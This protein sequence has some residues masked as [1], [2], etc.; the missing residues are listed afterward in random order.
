MC[1]DVRIEG[2]REQKL[3]LSCLCPR[4]FNEM[5][6]GRSVPTS[7]PASYSPSPTRRS[8]SPSPAFLT[9]GFIP[10]SPLRGR[11]Q[12]FGSNSQQQQPVA[13]QAGHGTKQHVS[14]WGW[15]SVY[16]EEGVGVGSVCGKGVWVWG[17]GGEGPCVCG[18]EGEHVR[19]RGEGECCVGGE[20]GKGNVVCVW[21]G[22]WE[23]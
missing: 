13:P 11:T 6:S 12:S 1:G 3:T 9:T 20:G 10:P 5:T 15:G 14:V 4:L 18:W 8:L 23:R 22:A 2:M 16:G 21:G 7:S 19:G 17:S